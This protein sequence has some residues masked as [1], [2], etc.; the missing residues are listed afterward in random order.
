MS[1]GEM[2]ARR[3]VLA[4]KCPSGE[5]SFGEM[6]ARR[7]FLAAKCPSGEMSSGEMSGGEVSGG[8]MSGGEMSG[9]HVNIPTPLS[10]HSEHALTVS[11][12]HFEKVLASIHI[13]PMPTSSAAGLD[14]VRP[15]FLKQLP[16]RAE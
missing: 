4:A 7:N 11:D 9:H 10:Q 8:E 16:L 14:G 6:S 5:M 13:H 1:F 15:N 2:S 3:N 12:E